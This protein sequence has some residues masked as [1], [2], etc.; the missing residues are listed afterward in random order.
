LASGRQSDVYIECKPT[1][2]LA[3]A[4]PLVGELVLE[5]IPH[6]TQAI[7]GL[8][9]GADPIADAV[10]LVAKLKHDRSIDTFMVRK[11]AKK[12]GLRKIIEGCAT[13]GT[14]VAVVDDVVTTGGSTIE[15]IQR[16]REA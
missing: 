12:H 2:M 13:P 11:E 5:R 7:G 10:S 8:T 14:R 6:D 15:A 9:F 3:D 1:T 16:C 4:K